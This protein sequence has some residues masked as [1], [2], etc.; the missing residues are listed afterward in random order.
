MKATGNWN[1]DMG[2]APRDGKQ[3]LLLTINGIAVTAFWTKFKVLKETQIALPEGHA[4]ELEDKE[5]W[6]STVGP[7]I[8]LIDPMIAWAKL[9]IPNIKI[10]PSPHGNDGKVID[11]NQAMRDLKNEDEGN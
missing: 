3:L 1:T 5:G 6:M 8:V 10:K 9:R 11:F 4:P 2:K 7:G